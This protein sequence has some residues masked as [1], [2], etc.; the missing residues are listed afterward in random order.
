MMEGNNV[1]SI[2]EFFFVFIVVLSVI[3]LL[4]RLNKIF[5]NILI[6]VL[7]LNEE[8]VVVWLSGLVNVIGLVIYFLISVLFIWFVKVL[9][10]W[11]FK[12]V[13]IIFLNNSWLLLLISNV[14]IMIIG[15]LLVFNNL[16]IFKLLIV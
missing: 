15:V 1:F 8:I 13:F 5:S 9:I 14:F 7:K 3:F 6:L 10:V 4:Y 16:F 12:K 11:F 2:L